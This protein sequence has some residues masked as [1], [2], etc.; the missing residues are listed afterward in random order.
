[1]DVHTGPLTRTQIADAILSA[2]TPSVIP[3]SAQT[4]PVRASAVAVS[5]ET[6]TSSAAANPAANG[7]AAQAERGASAARLDARAEAA[8]GRTDA[9]DRSVRDSKVRLTGDEQH[10]R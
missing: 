8:Q 7:K 2:L 4:I 6:P 10:E 3:S 9:M 1:R 5:Q